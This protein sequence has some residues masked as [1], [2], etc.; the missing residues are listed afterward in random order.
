MN[1]PSSLSVET[2][3]LVVPETLTR[4]KNGVATAETTSGSP[5]SARAKSDTSTAVDALFSSRPVGSTN[6]VL[7]IPKPAAAAFISAANSAGERPVSLAKITAA[8]LDDPTS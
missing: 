5:N 3:R 7:V 4:S 8:E 1:D 2:T 6:D